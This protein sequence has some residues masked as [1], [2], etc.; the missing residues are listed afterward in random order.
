MSALYSNSRLTRQRRS[1][2]KDNIKVDIAVEIAA[3]L[4]E[5]AV[6]EI[7]TG[8]L[9]L[10]DEREKASDLPLV[11]IVSPDGDV[12]VHYAPNA[13]VRL[14]DEAM[15]SAMDNLPRLGNYVSTESIARADRLHS[16]A[17]RDIIKRTD[18]MLRRA[19]APRPPR[20]G[21]PR[22]GHRLVNVNCECW[23]RQFSDL[24]C[25]KCVPVKAMEVP[26]TGG[27]R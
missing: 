14:A 17:Q 25:T 19:G 9:R 8:I 16:A 10:L 15:I 7:K 11:T 20:P 18:A 21:N 3:S 13:Y 1:L 2:A 27:K 6:V 22:P 24:A 26:M 5:D 23:R 12:E 4:F